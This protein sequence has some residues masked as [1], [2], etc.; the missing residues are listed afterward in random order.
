MNYEKESS[1]FIYG[2][3]NNDKHLGKKATPNYNKIPY[4]SP[5]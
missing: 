4:L 1:F 3:S 2:K 5:G